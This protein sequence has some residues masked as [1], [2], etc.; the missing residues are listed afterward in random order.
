[1]TYAMK[2]LVYIICGLLGLSS[3]IATSCVDNDPVGDSY[4]TFTG[5]MVT[6]YLI[7][8]E[9]ENPGTFS[10][11]IEVL[12]RAELWD[13][14]ST[15][16]TFTCFAPTDDAID[17]F[18][19]RRGYTSVSDMPDAE[20]DTLAWTHLF[21]IAYFTTDLGDG[22]LPTTNMNDRYVTL[23]CD[24]V[25]GNVKYYI[26]SSEMI[27]RDDSVENGVVHVLSDVITS[28]SVLLA[29]LVD[30]DPNLT[31]F[32]QA[33]TLTGLNK[34]IDN[35]LEDES[36]TIDADS[37]VANKNHI[38]TFGGHPVYWRYP[39]K[40]EYQYTI[41]AETDSIFKAHKI[42][43]IEELIEHAKEVYHKSYPNDLSYDN[44]Y[45]N[46]KNPLYRFVAYH[47][48]DRHATY[49][50]L[51]LSSAND[52]SKNARSQ[53]VTDK[54]DIQ[55]FYET[56]CPYTIMKVSDA[57]GQKY[58]NRRGLGAS[59]TAK[60]MGARILTASES[61]ALYA[62]YSD[63]RNGAYFYV[64][65]LVQYDEVTTNQILNCRMRIDATTLSPDFMTAGARN[66]V[67]NSDD[68]TKGADYLMMGF[69]TGCAKNFIFGEDTFFGVHER[70]WC[71]SFENDMC[72]CLNNFDIKFKLPP[73]PAGQTYE[74]RI[75]YQAGSDRTVVQ[76]Y[77]DDNLTGDIPC[78]IPVDLRKFGDAYGYEFDS[79]LVD[80]ESIEANDKSLRNQG[81]MKGP[82]GY[83]HPG[84]GSAMRDNQY[85]QCL[86]RILTTKYFEEGHDYYI[87]LRQ[88]LDNNAEMSLDY[89][90]I[91]PKSVYNGSK[92]EDR[93]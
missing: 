70:F 24:T 65:N 84:G 1:M 45:T 60:L 43:N 73:V 88:V 40:R 89:I 17:R 9:E 42:N 48:L 59:T 37:T 86:R 2:K 12:H 25:N 75:G 82:A 30:N 27:A 78:G 58:V 34:M 63:A 62:D 44:D 72:A 19:K 71:N 87:R 81:F 74:V 20:C 4:Y 56:C 10:D 35:N 55:E 6:D 68:N 18:L 21:K 26:N 57:A 66:I 52:W 69:K 3:L 39:S 54:I 31:I 28:S 23:T 50:E 93:Y 14:L 33:L 29:E 79:D 53:W 90:E 36:Y 49:D 67:R 32:G 85:K 91:V 11:F 15:Y 61:T 41:F 38:Y 92:A 8:R 83:C 76:I 64:D 51:T 80:E 47:I 22:S 7:N 13:L 16:G 46:P 5:E 77:F